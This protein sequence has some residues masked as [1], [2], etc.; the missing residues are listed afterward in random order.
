M[1]TKIAKTLSALL[2][3]TYT[4]YLK[5]QNFHW[6]VTGQNFASLHQL[7]EEQYTEYAGAVDEIAERIR[8][9]GARSPGSFTEFLKESSVSENTESLSSQAMVKELADDQERLRRRAQ[10]VVVAA[11]E[12]KDEGTAD[13]GIRRLQV[14]EKFEWMLRSCVEE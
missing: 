10:A 2:A 9:L 7:F 12:E 6:N 8:A 11:Q 4:L 14:H 13:L 1:T 5:T 3:D